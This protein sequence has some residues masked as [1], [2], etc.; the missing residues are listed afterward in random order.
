MGRVGNG[1]LVWVG[2]VVLNGDRIFRKRRDRAR[3]QSKFSSGLSNGNILQTL[4]LSLLMTEYIEIN[5]F[6]K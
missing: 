2:D 1:F 3:G 5:H 6:D 4:H